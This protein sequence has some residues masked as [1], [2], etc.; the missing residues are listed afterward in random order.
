MTQYLLSINASW[1]ENLSS[2]MPLLFYDFPYILGVLSM[3]TFHYL[4][5]NN[6]KLWLL[7]QK[8]RNKAG[9]HIM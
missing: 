6:D 8:F 4:I 2:I 1:A 7:I 3:N 5:V 9:L